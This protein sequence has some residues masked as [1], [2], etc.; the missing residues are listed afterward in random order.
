MEILLDDLKIN[1][2]N[3]I[4][5]FSNG[6]LVNIYDTKLARY[7]AT[8]VAVTSGMVQIPTSYDSYDAWLTLECSEGIEDVAIVR[9]YFDISTVVTKYEVSTDDAQELE[10]KARYLIDGET[11][12]FKFWLG[13]E[14][15]IGQGGDVLP[16]TTRI[17]KPIRL[18]ENSQLVYDLDNPSINETYL[19]PTLGYYGL[20]ADEEGD[21]PWQDTTREPYNNTRYPIESGYFAYY[22]DYLVEASWGFPVI[23]QAVKDAAGLIIADLECGNINLIGNYITRH[24]NDLGYTSIAELAFKGTGNFYADKL[25]APYKQRFGRVA[26]I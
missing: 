5:N 26:I 19:R 3:V 2:H 25:I 24:R 10:R 16:L 22:Y 9:P 17:V 13:I 21:P 11:G 6:E 4:V 20:L 18:W 1:N 7:V 8:D 15:Y 23:P 12:G 14:E